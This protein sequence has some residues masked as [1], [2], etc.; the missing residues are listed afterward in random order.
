MKIK[1]N[2]GIETNV[3]KEAMFQK[4]RHHGLPYGRLKYLLYCFLLMVDGF[5]GIVS[6][7]QTQSIIAQKYLLS[8]W[9][10]SEGEKREY[11]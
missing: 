11:R 9:I 1:E 4:T 2:V 7:G 8:D 3:E 5:I 6:L 10:L